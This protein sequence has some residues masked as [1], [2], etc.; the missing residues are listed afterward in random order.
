MGNFI[1]LTRRMQTFSSNYQN[2]ERDGIYR[3]EK[4]KLLLAFAHNDT[5]GL[6]LILSIYVHISLWTPFIYKTVFKS[7]FYTKV[8]IILYR[9]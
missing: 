3:K 9:S 6:S 1:P 2:N 4:G 8:Y 5:N 7:K